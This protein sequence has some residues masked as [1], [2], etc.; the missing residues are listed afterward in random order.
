MQT[1]SIEQ[2]ALTRR[3]GPA[4]KWLKFKDGN[5]GYCSHDEKYVIEKFTHY[6]WASDKVQ[7]VDWVLFTG[8]LL[9]DK[10]IIADEQIGVFGTLKEA[11]EAAAK[12]EFE[13]VIRIGQ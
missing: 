1:I 10:Q 9:N 6:W 4:I 2:T 3:G 12:L 8:E 13:K 5:H 7:R 11:K